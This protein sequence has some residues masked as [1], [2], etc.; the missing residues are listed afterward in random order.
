MPIPGVPQ[1]YNLPPEMQQM[2]ELVMQFLTTPPDQPAGDVATGL[3]PS[4]TP[5]A[6][7]NQTPEDQM[8]NM[9]L[10]LVQNA[11]MQQSGQQMTNAVQGGAGAPFG[12]MGGRPRGS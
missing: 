9:L 1:S 10:Q 5:P 3:P 12:A 11:Q 4:S 7:K 6:V 2:L 8:T